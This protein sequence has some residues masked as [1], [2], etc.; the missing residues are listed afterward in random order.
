M[1]AHTRD[2]WHHTHVGR[3]LSPLLSKASALTPTYSRC[4]RAA[5]GRTH[6]APRVTGGGG[7]RQ[8]VAQKRWGDSS[9]H[10]GS[11][12]I[13]W[14]LLRFHPRNTHVLCNFLREERKW[15]DAVMWLK[16]CAFAA[17]LPQSPS[18]VLLPFS[19]CE[20]AQ[21]KVR[22]GRPTWRR[23]TPCGSHI[24]PLPLLP[25]PFLESILQSEWPRST[26]RLCVTAKR[27]TRTKQQRLS[28]FPEPCASSRCLIARL[29]SAQHSSMPL[30]FCDYGA[31]KLTL[32]CLTRRGEKR[33]PG[34][35][36]TRYSTC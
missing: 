17:T 13:A 5:T 12:G 21:L 4:C 18:T 33:L 34:T 32:R 15:I 6:P 36:T 23:F 25:S 16:F 10:Q 8:R 28:F 26:S 35:T 1:R 3:R 9:A 2:T 19:G 31:C 27:V 14:G 7:E 20:N 22:E 29:R 11:V 30:H 24:S